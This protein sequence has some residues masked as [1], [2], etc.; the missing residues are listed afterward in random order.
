MKAVLAQL[1]LLVGDLSG[2]AAKILDAA[3]SAAAVK[4]DLLLT[5]ELSICSYQPEDLL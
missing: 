4:A 5:S 3:L 1:N 2:N